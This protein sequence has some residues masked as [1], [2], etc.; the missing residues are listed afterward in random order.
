MRKEFAAKF[1]SMKPIKYENREPEMPLFN[2][3]KKTAKKV[4]KTNRFTEQRNHLLN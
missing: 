3:N 4:L 1:S 2:L